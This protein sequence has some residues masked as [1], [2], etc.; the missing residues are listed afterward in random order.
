VSAPAGFSHAAQW[1]AWTKTWAY[2]LAPDDTAGPAWPLAGGAHP[3]QH[4]A[5]AIPTKGNAGAVEDDRSV[6]TSTDNAF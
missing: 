6:A 3:A 5:R 4:N 2:L 1:Q